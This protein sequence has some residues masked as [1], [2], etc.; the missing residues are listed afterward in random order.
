MQ[1][2]IISVTESDRVFKEADQTLFAS[3]SGDSNPIHMDAVAA[4]RT[5]TGE[6]V[7]HGMHI[8]IWLLDTLARRGIDLS[9][10]MQ[11]KVRFKKF[12][13]LG[14][15]VSYAIRKADDVGITINVTSDRLSSVTVQL[16]FGARVRSHIELLGPEVGREMRI[17]LLPEIIGTSGWLHPTSDNSAYSTVFPAAASAL[18]ARRLSGLAEFSRLVG[19][20]CPGLHSIFSSF[21]VDLVDYDV[22]KMGIGFKVRSVDDRLG[23]VTIDVAGDGL[24]GE[25]LSF[26]R[27]PPVEEP[28]IR[29]IAAHITPG[30]FSGATALILGGSRGL[31]AVTAKLLAAGGARPIITYATGSEEASRVAA[32][33]ND[34]SGEKRCQIRP[35]DALRPVSP[36]LNDLPTVSHLYYFATPPIFIQ[37]VDMFNFDLHRL[38][39]KFY[40]EAFYEAWLALRRSPTSIFYPSSVAVEE[41]P[42]GM[43]EYAMAK[44]AGEMLCS[45]L[46]STN[47][48]LNITVERL[49]RILT[50]QTA[51]VMPVNNAD[52]LTIMLPIVRAV[53]QGGKNA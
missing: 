19:M 41:R 10:L 26:V 29:D 18:G 33:I 2:H 16:R 32:D 48:G 5:Q 38:F 14:S 6:R 1:D 39:L 47:P 36:Q 30:E 35:F 7:V 11:I 21:T 4:R 17:L 52:A 8:V 37:K 3:L 44:C 13:R 28:A 25:V 50:D 46:A 24:Q 49:P 40:A 20:I 45:E 51:T 43:L 42:A 12:V 53:Q 27:Q 23:M 15:V 9:S 34:W 22:A 31:G